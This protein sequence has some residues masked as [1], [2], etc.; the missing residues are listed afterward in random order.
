MQR[1]FYTLDRGRYIITDGDKQ[2][3]KFKLKKMPYCS[4]VCILCDVHI[5]P[6][7]RGKGWGKAIVHKAVSEAKAMDYS[8]IVATVVHDNE[9]MLKCLKSWRTMDRYYNPKTGNTVLLLSN[10]IKWYN[11]LKNLK[12]WLQSCMFNTADRHL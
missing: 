11:K 10:N 7:Y 5:A 2:I 1:M 4:A 12:Q 9:P 8:R 3:G 6:E